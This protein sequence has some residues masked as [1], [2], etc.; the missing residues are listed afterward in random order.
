MAIMFLVQLAR[1]VNDSP[2]FGSTDIGVTDL[3]GIGVYLLLIIGCRAGGGP[4]RHDAC[5]RAAAAA[6]IA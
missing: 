5:D 3:A 6:C 1:I 4:A 2:S